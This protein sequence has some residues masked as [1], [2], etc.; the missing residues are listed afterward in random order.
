ML[1]VCVSALQGASAGSSSVVHMWTRWR[2]SLSAE[3]QVFCSARRPRTPERVFP[4]VSS[5]HFLSVS[6]GQILTY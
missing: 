4:T 1:G 6:R 3:M 2:M 5:P